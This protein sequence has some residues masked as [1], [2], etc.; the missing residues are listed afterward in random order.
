M[1][2]SDYWQ[3]KID[4]T[5][6]L[7]RWERPSI[8]RKWG[9]NPASLK[10]DS[11][12]EPGEIGD[13]EVDDFET[14]YDYEFSKIRDQLVKWKEKGIIGDK[15]IYYVVSDRK[16]SMPYTWDQWL[17]LS[18]TDLELLGQHGKKFGGLLKPGDPKTLEVLR[19]TIQ[20]EIQKGLLN[21]NLN[22]NQ[23]KT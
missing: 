16:Y 13:P 17:N 19:E 15:S 5:R 23:S 12:P 20:Q 6:I 7:G 22:L 11:S 10:S 2:A 8:T 9:L 4:H 14:V 1:V 21:S 3:N 18:I